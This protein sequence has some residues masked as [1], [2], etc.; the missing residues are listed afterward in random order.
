MNE[1]IALIDGVEIYTQPNL[2]AWFYQS[3]GH[4]VHKITDF[5]LSPPTGYRE[6]K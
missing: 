2:R 4:R 3:T 6:E 1:I 5:H